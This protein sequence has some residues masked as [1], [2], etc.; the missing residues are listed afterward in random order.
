MN[1]IDQSIL[2][3]RQ[4]SGETRSI[5]LMVVLTGVI[6]VLVA[7][8]FNGFQSNGSPANR[9]S[10][11]S[12][13]E[14]DRGLPV[15]VIPVKYVERVTY[16]REFTGEIRARRTSDL[17]FERA[18]IIARVNCDEGETVRQ[19]QVLAELDVVELG[20]ARRQLD[21]EVS[22]AQALLDELVAGPR[23]ETIAASRANVRALKAEL[24]LAAQTLQRRDSLR[25]TRSIS[26]EEWEQAEARYLSAQARLDAA[27]K[28]LDELVAGNREEVIRAQRS[29]VQSL[30][31][32][33]D[34]IDHD[35]KRSKLRA[36]YDGSVSRRL[37]DEGEYAAPGS[38]A[39]RITESTHLEA[40]VGVP[41]ATLPF[42][43]VKETLKCQ[44]DG[45]ETKATV[46]RILPEAE[47]QTRTVPIVL[48]LDA[49]EFKPGQVL[50][51][52]IPESRELSGVW[53]PTSALLPATK[54]LWSLFVAAKEGPRHIAERRLVE[55]LMT[56]G[57]RTLVR[58]TLKSGE[59]LITEGVHRV[60]KGQSVQV[61]TD[62]SWSF[63]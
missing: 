32:Q 51:V 48:K 52:R 44:I 23:K 18:A 30:T 12:G 16:S 14:L 57:D 54:G 27:Q 53:V 63:E 60:A 37:V 28:K 47:K 11:R 58:G 33:R 8:G 46:A 19:D 56:E 10:N 40:I 45:R 13:P 24:E 29:R 3:N 61:K 43:R 9:D 26:D 59:L 22:S 34:R 5:T 2:T 50:K 21:A 17:A 39:L 6:A 62:D 20:I 7:F 55:V 15:T 25:R 41:P 42:I 1:P 31:A 49:S 38:P 36:P 4:R 35:I